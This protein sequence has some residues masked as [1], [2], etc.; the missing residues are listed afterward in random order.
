MSVCVLVAVIFAT[1]RLLQPLFFFLRF[2]ASRT[3]N[4]GRGGMYRGV[5]RVP[6]RCGGR[7]RLARSLGSMRHTQGSEKRRKTAA[8]PRPKR[9]R[10]NDLCAPKKKCHYKR[11]PCSE[12]Q[13]QDQRLAFL[14]PV[15]APA[16]PESAGQTP[17]LR[18]RHHPTPS[19]VLKTRLEKARRRKCAFKIRVGI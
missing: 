17:C 3:T 1:K 6:R 14:S 11:S 7:P 9:A 19:R 2:R 8:S 18:R 15:G 16:Q 10:K 5:Y 4:G 13:G 12:G